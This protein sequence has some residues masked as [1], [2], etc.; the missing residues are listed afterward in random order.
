MENP[1]DWPEAR[2]RALPRADLLVIARGTVPDGIYNRQVAWA[3]N[4]L[5]RRAFGRAKTYILD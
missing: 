4:E 2:V 5:R 3:D 1:N